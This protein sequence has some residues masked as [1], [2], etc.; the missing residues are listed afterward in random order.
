MNIPISQWLD[1]TNQ[2][3]SC[4]SIDKLV[5]L[6]ILLV[7]RMM[8]PDVLAECRQKSE[9]AMHQKHA[10]NWIMAVVII[11]IWVILGALVA[12]WLSKLLRRS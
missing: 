9:Q 2:W 4:N 6:G 11:S 8:I 1:E 12:V 5:P 3:I 7:S 10:K